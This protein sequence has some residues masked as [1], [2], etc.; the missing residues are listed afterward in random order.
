MVK[1]KPVYKD[2]TWGGTKIRDVLHKDIGDFKKVAESWELATHTNG[3]CTIAEGKYAG[4][5]LDEYF[6]IIGWEQLGEKT[7]GTRQLPVMIK[8]IDAK[9]N[10]SIQVHP[11]DEYA[12]AH[13]SDSG[14]NEMW[15]ILEADE[16]AFIYLGFNRDVTKEEVKTAVE[17]GTIE[18]LLNRVPVK[19]GDVYY[20]PAGTVHAIGA[21][22]LICEVQ[23][24]S[25][26][27]YRLYDY[28]RNNPNRPCE[29]EKVLDVLNCKKT[30]AQMTSFESVRALARNMLGS[31]SKLVINEYNAEG[32]YSYHSLSSRF[33]VALCLEGSGTIESNESAVLR[34][35]DT[36]FFTEPQVKI[37][38]KCRTLIVSVL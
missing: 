12:K 7:K 29:P 3:E 26:A 16:D 17:K 18:A 20:I 34:Q 5:R 9:E 4:M 27:T 30:D 8:Y 10:L 37:C 19:K 1:L 23:Q 25:D 15:Y 38:G 6:D 24:T 31:Q 28:G 22:C 21:G 11:T 36:W 13:S 35:G 33:T 14:K 2:F 32:E